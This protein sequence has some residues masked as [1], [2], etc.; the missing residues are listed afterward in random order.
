MKRSILLCL[1]LLALMYISPAARAQ[2]TSLETGPTLNTIVAEPSMSIYPNPNR[3]DEAH[4]DFKGFEAK[5]LLVVVYD[6]FGRELYT[7]IELVEK[8][9]FLFSFDPALPKGV[10]LIIASANDVVFRQKLIVR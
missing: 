8:E 3:G 7:K 4:V 9:G 1:F 10:Y 6:M 5:D 2:G